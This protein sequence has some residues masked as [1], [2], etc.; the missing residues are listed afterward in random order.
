VKFAETEEII[1]ACMKSSY[2]WDELSV[3]KLTINMRLS[4]IQIGIDS[5][6]VQFGDQY[7]SSPE[8][9]LDLEQLNQQNKYGSLILTIGEGFSSHLDC[10]LLCEE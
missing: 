5:K 6:V 10:Q 1:G 9:D 7:L 2:L 8:Y 4:H 3:L